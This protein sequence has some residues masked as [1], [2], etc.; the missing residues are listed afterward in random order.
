[1]LRTML[2]L[3]VLGVSVAA[4]LPAFAQNGLGG[5]IDSVNR[6]DRN[7]DAADRNRDG[8]LSRKEAAAGHVAFVARN[9]DAIDTAKRGQV[10]KDDVHAFIQDWLMRRQPAPA[11]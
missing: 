3:L 6:L 10:S 11:E 5:I 4:P 9:F 2:A 8:L 1:M 7:F